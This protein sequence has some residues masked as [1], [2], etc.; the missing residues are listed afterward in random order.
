MV[1]KILMGLGALIV[2]AAAGGGIFVMVQTSAFDASLA[3]KYEIPLPAVVIS[4]DPAVL[5]R[6]R[7]LMAALGGCQ[8]CHGEN[9]GGGKVEKLGPI[10]TFSYPNITSGKDGTLSTYSD[11]ELARLIRHGVKRDGTTVRF[12]PSG[13]FQWW[14]M[15]DI[16]ALIS[17]LRTIPPV[18]GN[19]GGVEIGTLGK[20]LDR[21]D[22]LPIDVARRI[23]H[24]KKWPVLAV[25]ATAEYGSQLVMLCT[26][27]HGPN[28]SGGPI[29]GAPADMAI[30]LNLTP[31][32]TGTKGW[33]YEDFDKILKTGIRKDG[34][35]LDAMMPIDITRNYSETEVKAL[36]AHLQTV[37]P[38]AFGGR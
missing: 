30:P 9:L 22:S 37:P 16:E 5:E 20:I 32:E 21:M 25:A 27:C 35:K 36:W 29:P 1:K 33:A 10:G 18:D 6:G 19:P 3:K 28:L 26:G 13:D 4:V 34:K 11:G 14:P 17:T 24:D 8:S 23:D 38:K 12:M 2:L 15:E 31:H 7:H